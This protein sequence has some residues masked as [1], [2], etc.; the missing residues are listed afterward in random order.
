MR[1]RPDRQRRL[2]AG[3]TLIELMIV[4]AIM[5]II[6][7][8]ALPSYDSY[9]ARGRRADARTQLLQVAQ[10]MQRFYAAND[11]FDVDRSSNPVLGQIAGNLQQSPADGAAVYTL[12]IPTATLNN[13]AYTLQMVPVPGG[14]M[15]HDECGTFTLTSTGVRGVVVGGT[16]GSTTLRDKCWK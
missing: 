5:A 7:T 10:F 6:A 4:V 12:A 1:L 14:R 3:F 8:I 15:A 13:S 11:R 9:I 2:V 16:A